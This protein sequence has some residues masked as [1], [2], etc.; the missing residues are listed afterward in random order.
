MAYSVLLA[1]T[2]SCL[3]GVTNTQDDDTMQQN[4]N[5]GVV[6]CWECTIEKSMDN[7]V[8]SMYDETEHSAVEG[9]TCK[10]H[11]CQNNEDWCLVTYYR[12]RATTDAAESKR[13]RH[14]CGNRNNRDTDTRCQQLLM[15][16]KGHN[17]IVPRTCKTERSD[18]SSIHSSYSV[19]FSALLSL[20]S[21]LILH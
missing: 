15:D 17:K 18:S 14:E 21:L 3:L 12:I 2:L 4:N 16:D 8:I 5:N 9:A 10:N 13:E 11:Q 1:L 20:L 7:T 6:Y 19:C